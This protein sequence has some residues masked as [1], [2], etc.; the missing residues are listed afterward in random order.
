MRDASI[1]VAL[2]A[3]VL[4][5]SVRP[6]AGQS[7]STPEPPLD[8]HC[9]CANGL[10]PV[11]ANG[12]ACS[13]GCGLRA[14][15]ERVQALRP[16]ARQ[17]CREGDAAGYAC[18]DVDLLSFLPLAEIGGGSGNDVWGWTDPD[19]GREYAI[20]GRSNGTAFVDVTDPEHPLYLGDL[21]TQTTDSLWRDVKVYADH[22]FVVSE[23][24]N[25]G[26]QVF[27]LRRLASVD[28]P[29][30][31]FP[32]TA[33]YTGFGSAHNIAIDA[34]AGFAYAVGTRTCAGGLHAVNIQDPAQP[35]TAGCYAVDG[36]TH[37][38][39]CVV[40][41]G[42]D[43]THAGRE[44]C[45]NS[46]EDTLTIVDV[47]DKHAQREVSRTGYDAS[48][49]THQ[50][51]LTDDRR[52]FL[53][54][55]E[56]DERAY[57]TPTRTFVWDVSDLDAPFIAHV[58]EGPVGSIDHNLFIRGDLAYESNYR[59]GLRV[60]A[61]GDLATAPPRE[62]GFF[63]IYPADDGPEFNGAW[64]VYPYFASGTVLVNGIEQGLFLLRPRRAPS[65]AARGLG[66]T[67]A[68]TSRPA[69]LG[70]DLV[71]VAR[72]ANHGPGRAQAVQLTMQHGDGASIASAVAS[73]GACATTTILTCA[74]DGLA[75]GADATVIVTLR[76]RTTG[77]LVIT[78]RVSA[79]H[80][81]DDPDD[82]VA[83]S[84]ETVETPRR[85]LV[86]VHPNGGETL[87]AGRAAAV[88][89]TLRGVDGGVRVELS[90][91]DGR[92]WVE[93]AGNAPNVGFHDWVPPAGFQPG[94]RVRVTS[95]ADPRLV[96]T[97]AAPFLIR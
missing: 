64:S 24:P 23:A 22:A 62:I 13:C 30:V 82:T 6:G 59:S 86:L 2:L 12:R 57:G 50:G 93:L 85:E 7:P 44:I 71:Y 63:D 55:D 26:L 41:D 84:L 37:D 33:H 72:V 69:F 74:L 43:R 21:P 76:A 4:T 56:G 68:A 91:D 35:R 28:G 58:Y 14:D 9:D 38:A 46:N 70:A 83:T 73:R 45:F 75:A 18:H 3:A 77:D 29:P 31:T 25:H 42:P 36:Y 51:W 81:A 34:A 67:L 52:F 53:V 88:Q 1:L 60:L 96:A 47:S 66:V 97:S 11:R 79:D 39:Q 15:V 80:Q 17:E 40:Y 94:A 65:G 32:P 87:R 19:T 90:R 48:A 49:Y 78:A 61:L 89:W 10:C 27:D 92:T 5:G 8:G 20:A 54:D 16:L 95:V